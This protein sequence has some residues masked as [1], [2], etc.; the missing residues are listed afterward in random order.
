MKNKWFKYGLIGIIAIGALII[1]GAYIFLKSYEKSHTISIDDYLKQD[2]V[3][4]KGTVKQNLGFYYLKG[5]QKKP[6]SLHV[7]M[8]EHVAKGDPLYTYVDDTLTTDEKSVSLELDNKRIEKEQIEGQIQSY[9]AMQ[10]SASENKRTEIE[11]QL[12]WLDSELTKAENNISILEEKQQAIAKKTENLTITA[13]TDGV[14]AKIDEEQLHAYTSDEQLKP[15]IVISN[16]NF[17]VKGHATDEQIPF[18]EPQ[19]KFDGNIK[20]IDK[21]VKGQLS[22]VSH[23]A[24]S[25]LDRGDL[26]LEKPKQVQHLYDIEGTFDKTEDLLD[27]ETF[28]MKI[29]P[30][31][32]NHIWL[33]KQYVNEKRYTKD[34]QGKKLAKP[35][36]K[37][38]VQK[39]YGK[40]TNEE[41]V[42]VEK[43]QSGRYLVTKGLSVVDSIR[44]YH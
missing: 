15:I 41:E 31:Y 38:F 25:N 10:Q 2:V 6:V 43:V 16:D 29:Y 44:A 30:S 5:N 22:Q 27:G 26:Q 17:I 21:N 36:K 42:T 33:P 1:G 8:G 37:Y 20:R 14:V 12:N 7:K 39:I 23:V 34:K 40:E 11:G 19:L 9:E 13:D 32:K 3:K 24:L 4:V 28:N 18:L 35:E